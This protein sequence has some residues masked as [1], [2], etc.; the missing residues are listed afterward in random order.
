MAAA[1]LPGPTL[2][3]CPI[4][5]ASYH[6]PSGR[7]ETFSAAAVAASAAAAAAREA[8]GGAQR[9]A[10]APRVGSKGAA[11]SPVGAGA[12]RALRHSVA[13]GDDAGDDGRTGGRA[14]VAAGGAEAA[15]REV[16]GD[17][18]WLLL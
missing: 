5:N 2:A 8:W 10:I 12:A 6:S 7:R 11:A 18:S 16:A 1:A 13:R 17:C 9:S 4:A 14:R 15:S 3:A